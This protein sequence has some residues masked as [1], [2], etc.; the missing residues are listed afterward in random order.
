M[1]ALALAALI[2]IGLTAGSA[3]AET[4]NDPAGRFTFNAPAGWRVQAQPGSDHH[5]AALA[6]NPTSDCYFIGVD[7]PATVSSTANA[8]RNTTDPLSAESWVAIANQVSDFF[9]GNSAQ[10]VSQSVDTSGFWPVQRAELGG[11]SRTAFGAV[12]VR[13]GIEIRAFC[14]GARSGAAYDA[15][16]ASLSNPNDA[17]WQT[18]A[19]EQAAARAAAEAQAEAPPPEQE[20][21]RHH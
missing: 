19:E 11:P 2:G 6:F 5:S 7:N 16:I 14:S 20:H 4:W 17:S 12:L 9:P 13:P 8:A 3:F 15:I 10:L 18:A 1:R 21:R